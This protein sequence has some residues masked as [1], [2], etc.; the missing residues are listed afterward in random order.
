MLPD[1]FYP[2]VDGS[3]FQMISCSQKMSDLPENPGISDSGASNHDAIHS[4]PVFIFKR[5]LGTVNIA[6]AKDGNMHTRIIF[7]SCDQRP[8]SLSFIQLRPGPSMD[9][10]GANA[11]VL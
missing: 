3:R 8:V 6:V 7:N 5:F 4:I 9:S 1:H 10:E 11:L 2:L